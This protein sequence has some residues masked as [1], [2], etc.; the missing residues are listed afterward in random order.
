MKPLEEW[1]E[2]SG[3][4]Q[5][6]ISEMGKKYTLANDTQYYQIAPWQWAL[7]DAGKYIIEVMRLCDDNEL[8]SKPVPR[9][10]FRENLLKAAHCLQ[11]AFTK[12]KGSK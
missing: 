2:F 5:Q 3:E 4:M 8:T 11:I 12:L 7:G 6:H 9:S 10:M 1:A